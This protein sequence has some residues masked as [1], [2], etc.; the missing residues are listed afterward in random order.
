MP[1]KKLNYFSLIVKIKYYFTEITKG[2]LIH[3]M[4]E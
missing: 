3:S 4:H 2:K 1:C